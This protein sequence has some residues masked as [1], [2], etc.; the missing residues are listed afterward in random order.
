MENKK[1]WYKTKPALI[2]GG[3]IAFFFVVGSCSDFE[4]EPVSFQESGV[5]AI[6]K[7]DLDIELVGVEKY[8]SLS[9]NNMFI[10]SYA[11]PEGEALL[12]A[13]LKVT[14]NSSDPKALWTI[15]EDI[16]LIDETGAVYKPGDI[17]FDAEVLLDDIYSSRGLQRTGT[18]N[19]SDLLPGLTRTYG[20]TYRVVNN[21]N[22]YKL[23]K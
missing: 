14:N 8:T 20:L 19:S 3:I 12:I 10:E 21:A 4:E 1:P 18:M 5:V 9:S 2:T 23:T 11:S 16:K 22:E 13:K 15:L 7:R 17:P 6:Q